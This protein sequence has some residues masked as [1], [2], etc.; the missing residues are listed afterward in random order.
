MLSKDANDPNAHVG[1]GLVLADQGS[2]QAAVEE[3]KTALRLGPQVSGV[4]YELGRSYAQLKM[5]DDAI[6]A[7]IKQRD[8]DGDDA[9]VESA[10]AEAY[11]AKGMTQQAQQAAAKAAEL[12]NSQRD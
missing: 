4:Y 2:H 6:A 10:L 12:R 1:L 7:Y 9:E 11:Q 5:Y 8:H 3:F